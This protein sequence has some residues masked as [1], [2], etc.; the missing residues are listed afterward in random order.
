MNDSRLPT[1]FWAKVDRT[2]DCWIWT[3]AR[4]I[5]GYGQFWHLG[6]MSQAHRVAYESLVG[7]IPNGMQLDHVC[8][9]RCCVNPEHL[10]PVT[11]KENSENRATGNR[12]SVSGI[13]GVGWDP[14][15]RQWFAC[16]THDGR[17]YYR[18]YSRDRTAAASAAVALRN[19]LHSNNLSDKVA[20]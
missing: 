15:S 9:M 12:G 10:H 19:Q 16:V 2:G 14:R 17:A 8:H 20:G 13:R 18:A 6:K 4:H 11:S 3:A 7:P 5:K 1:R